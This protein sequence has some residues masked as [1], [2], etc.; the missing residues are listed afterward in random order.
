VASQGG[1][2]QSSA[3]DR[4]PTDLYAFGNR[5]QPRAPRPSD[6]GVN[7]PD[8]LVGPESPPTPHGASTPGDPAQTP[9]TGHYHHLPAGTPLP[10]G[11][12]VVADGSDVLP[13]SALPPTHHTLFPTIEM[14]LREF[15]GHFLA[16]PWQHAGKK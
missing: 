3:P 15:I 10:E 5:Q 14:T 1:G 4:T 9:L 2:A 12:G 13:G 7:G 8:D 16:L 6:F 11:L